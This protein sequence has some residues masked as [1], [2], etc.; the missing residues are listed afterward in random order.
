MAW[1]NGVANLRLHGTTGER[2]VDRFKRE[3]LQPV[4]P[5]VLAEYL[6][7]EERQVGPD[8]FVSYRGSRYG[9]S[10]RF[11][12]RTV[13]VR[14]KAGVVE[15]WL[16]ERKLGSHKLAPAGATVPVARQWDELPVVSSRPRARPVGV[17]LPDPAVEVRSLS[18]HEAAAGDDAG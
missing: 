4:A 10:W 5:R 2:P 14:V 17:K 7:D 16:G 13:R 8:G 18:A 15:L 11:A 1:V 12:G 6:A 9:V 3:E